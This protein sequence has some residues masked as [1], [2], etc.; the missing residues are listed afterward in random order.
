MITSKHISEI[1]EEYLTTKN[2]RNVDVVFYKNPTPSELKSY[3]LKGLGTMIRFVADGEHQVVYV[4][5]AYAEIH[6]LG[7]NVL[8]FNPDPKKT[9]D[10]LNGSAEVSSSGLA[11]M[12][13]WTFEYE[14]MAKEINNQENKKFFNKMMSHTWS[15]LERYIKGS[16]IY[17]KAQRRHVFGD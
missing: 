8:G 16:D 10:L 1:S 14:Q 4:W 15:W 3:C 2:I 6:A 12:K 7:R 9:P 5:D 11:T 17:M 13:D